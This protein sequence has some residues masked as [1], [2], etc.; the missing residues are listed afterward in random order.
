MQ[1]SS[2]SVVSMHYTL[3][4]PAGEVLDSSQGK[5]PLAYLHGHGNIIPGLEKQ[6]EGKVVGDKLIAEV[7]AAEA[8]GEPNDDLVVEA[9]RDQFPGDVDL[10]PGMRFQAQ[11]PQGPRIAQIKAVDGDKVT[12]DTNH[13]LAGVDLKFDVE[14][15]EVREASKEEIDHGHVHTGK[16]GH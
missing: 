11:T 4:D 9:S 14:I 6:L 16:D 7:P 1:I 8:Y 5:D 13:P 12:V 15:I 2:N 10:Q 3:T